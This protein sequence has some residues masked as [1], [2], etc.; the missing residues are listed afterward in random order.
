MPRYQVKRSNCTQGET[1]E[2]IC[3]KS[4]AIEFMCSEVQE[5][6]TPPEEVTVTW[7]GGEETYEFK[8][9]E[10]TCQSNKPQR[11]SLFQR[12]FGKR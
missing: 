2:A 7:I 4:A 8:K 5:G 11:A 9:K 1:I 6:G 10:T 12:L 3:P